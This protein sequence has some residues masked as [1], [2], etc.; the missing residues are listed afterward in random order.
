VPTQV[1]Q[2]ADDRLSRLSALHASGVLTD[3]EFETQR[4]RILGE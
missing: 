2:A 1:E 3:E 4:R